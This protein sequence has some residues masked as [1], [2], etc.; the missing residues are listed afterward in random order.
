VSVVP[1]PALLSL[2]TIDELYL[3]QGRFL[4]RADIDEILPAMGNIERNHVG[5]RLSRATLEDTLGIDLSLYE[6]R[7]QYALTNYITYGSPDTAKLGWGERAGVLNSFM[8]AFGKVPAVADDWSDIIKIANG[9]W[10]TQRSEM[11]ENRSAEHF[12]KIY[13]RE[14]NRANPHDDAAVTVVAYGLRPANRNMESE[15]A[16]IRIFKAI[17]GYAPT[18]AVDWDVARAIAYSGATR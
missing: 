8:A 3:D 7:A 15:A 10:P 14:P 12:R 4:V 2:S 1:A 16:A 11:A 18:G 5:E 17:Y 6:P 9:R 13:L